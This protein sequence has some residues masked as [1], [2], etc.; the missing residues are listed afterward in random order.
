MSVEILIGVFGSTEATVRG[1]FS[2]FQGIV[3]YRS[4][5]MELLNTDTLFQ[6]FSLMSTP[7]PVYNL[8][9]KEKFSF[10][11]AITCSN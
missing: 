5:V 11:F 1:I 7:C 2:L 10:S 3:K 9:F 4:V 8:M 6:L